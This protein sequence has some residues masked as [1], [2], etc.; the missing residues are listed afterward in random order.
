M[1]E[2]GRKFLGEM[3][4]ILSLKIKTNEE[5]FTVKFAVEYKIGSPWTLILKDSY[6]GEISL[7]FGN[8]YTY[9]HICLFYERLL[10]YKIKFAK[11]VVKCLKFFIRYAV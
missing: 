3:N 7:D 1:V 10:L 9:L 2:A 4:N 5:E 8:Y 11:N 6:Y